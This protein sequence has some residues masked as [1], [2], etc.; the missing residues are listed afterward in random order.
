M[1]LA[2]CPSCHADLNLDTLVQ[3]SSAKS[4]L[5]V[6]AKLKPKLATNLIG[7][8]ALWRPAKSDLNND[9]AVKLINEVLELSGNEQA[10]SAALEQTV[11]A[12]KAKRHSGTYQA[13]KNHS[14]LCQVLSTTEEKYHHPTAS[15]TK[16]EG[17]QAVIKKGYE[18]STE[19]NQEM[20]HKIQDQYRT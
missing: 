14:Y 18:E 20:F 11:M 5:A 16:V 10:L 6:V 8:I 9:R 3:D 4:L 2:R 1:K 17:S 12:I 13:F 19:T 7:Y 15:T